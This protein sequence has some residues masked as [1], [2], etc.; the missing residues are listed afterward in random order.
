MLRGAA[1]PDPGACFSSRKLRAR[2]RTSPGHNRTAPVSVRRLA[3][4]PVAARLV[5]AGVVLPRLLPLL[6]AGV[7]C[8]AFFQSAVLHASP[9][10]QAL[11]L[12]VCRLPVWL[13]WPDP[14]CFER[15]CQRSRLGPVA[16]RRLLVPMAA[17][18]EE[19]VA[20]VRLLAFVFL[21]CLRGW[22][23]VLLGRLL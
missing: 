10:A 18:A 6:L 14:L 20:A 12:P 9:P 3:M 17:A 4:P 1:S 5:A 13:G 16:A 21:L 8:R 7:A 11:V 22:S 23:L 2:L 15:W 19:G